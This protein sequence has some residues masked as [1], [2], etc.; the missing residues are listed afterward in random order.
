MR[1]DLL[2]TVRLLVVLTVLCGVIYPGTVTAVARLCFPRQAE[3]SLV[4]LDGRAVG[5]ALIAQ[6]FR[7]PDYF[8]PR[9]SATMPPYNASL[10]GGSNDG[11]LSDRLRARVA[12]RLADLRGPAPAGAG[13]VPCDLVT[14]SGSGLDPHIS[15]ASAYWQAPRVARARRVSDAAVNAAIARHI[16]P[17]QFGLLGEARVNV[18]ELNL[19][20][21]G[22]RD[23]R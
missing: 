16:E 14:A 13:P 18:L 2:V 22:L 3:G 8:W 5:S 4:H 21:N 15:P 9:P 11:P 6:E 1:N 12:G 7:S 17:P 19:E 23:E 20:L 10:S